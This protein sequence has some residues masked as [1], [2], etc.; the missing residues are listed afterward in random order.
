MAT[1]THSILNDNFSGQITHH[2]NG[3]ALVVPAA[4]VEDRD[5]RVHHLVMM[6]DF[7]GFSEIRID[8]HPTQQGCPCRGKA[9]CYASLTDVS[10][11]LPSKPRDTRSGPCD[12]YPGHPIIQPG[13]PG[14]LPPLE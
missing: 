5:Q 2:N 10:G 6:P 4:E 12:S 3:G 14:G 1:G 8:A 13:G 9:V 7:D 11:D